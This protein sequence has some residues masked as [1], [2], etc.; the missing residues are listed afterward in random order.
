LVDVIKRPVDPAFAAGF[1]LLVALLIVFAGIT[2]WNT[3]RLIDAA[4]SV[5]HTRVV[6]GE[7]DSLFSELRD[8]E[9][10]ER[11]YVITG[12]PSYLDPYK[13]ALTA[14][15]PALERI[16][17]LVTD[18]AAQRGRAQR[19]TELVSE[20]LDLLRTNVAKRD[21]SGIAAASDDLIA[22]RGK[23]RMDAIRALV[24]EMQK[25]ERGLLSERTSSNASLAR[26]AIVTLSLGGLLM[27]AFLGIIWL[28]LRRDLLRRQAAEDELRRVASIVASSEDAVIGE[29]LTGHVTAWNAAAE[30]LFGYTAAEIMGRSVSILEPGGLEENTARTLEKIHRGERVLQFDTTRLRKDGAVIPVSVSVSPIRDATGRLVGASKIVR[31]ISERKEAERQLRLAKEAAEEANLAKD[32]FLAVLSHELRTPL[33]PVLLTAQA[34]EKRDL[35][36]DL[37]RSIELIRRNV[38][39]EA[40]LVDDLLDVTRITH[41]KLELKRQ[42]VDLHRLTENAV[43]TCRG[44]AL[45]R[46]QALLV[47]LG[48]GEHFA[49][50]DPARMQQVLWN[51]V[52]NAVKFTGEGGTIRVASDNPSPGTIRIRVSDTGRGIA[53]EA[54][55]RV[56]DPFEQEGPGGRSHK[57]L[58]LGLAISRALIQL[59]GGSIHAQSPGI[60]LGATFTVTLPA[61][62]E[63]RFASVPTGSAGR[64]PKRPLT[65]LLAE[66]HVDTAEALSQL[67][68]DEGHRILAVS[69][70]EE[71]IAVGR[72]EDVD[73]LITDLGLP[74]GSGH[75]LLG[76][77]REVR[78]V[79]GI[80]LS[81][82]GMERDVA[83]S[84]EAGFLDHLTKPVNVERLLRV[85]DQFAART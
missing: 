78:P 33:T 30:R 58:G 51:L 18:N 59:H 60:G 53:P 5:E 40:L 71:A 1:G 77:L 65:I 49:E 28:L 83:Q 29:S 21:E 7:L 55:E 38:D 63:K 13:T 14:L 10:G 72:R 11:G 32:R 79:Q 44:D 64:S 19:L 48:A 16:R 69:T 12:L 9:A 22:S 17:G 85:I 74:D 35:P 27:A 3:S 82:Y 46:R 67:L 43:E 70:V 61:H 6:L 36:A 80:V 39:L 41:G 23:A 20:Q 54:L 42:P 62:V 81:G 37:H 75:Q 84:R 47:E 2:Y 66:D 57:G 25:E 76:R 15:P 52:Q 31:D 34:L 4:N 68:A 45:D 50:A 26:T 24:M 73:L 8:A 56:F